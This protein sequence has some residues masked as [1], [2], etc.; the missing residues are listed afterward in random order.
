VRWWRQE[1]KVAIKDSASISQGKIGQQSMRIIKV[2]LD[3]ETAG[4]YALANLS[5]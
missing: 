1:G 3:R 5:R 2:F 4:N